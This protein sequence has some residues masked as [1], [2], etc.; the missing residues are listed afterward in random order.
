MPPAIARWHAFVAEPSAQ[1]LR[2]MLAPDAVFRSPVVHTPQVGGE[3]AFAYLRAAAHVLGPT[4]RYG[5]QWY[6]DDD[7]VLRFAAEVDG[8]AVD[9]IDMITWNDDGLITDFTVMVRPLKG[10]QALMSAMAQQLQQQ[11]H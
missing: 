5:R 8:F 10:L 11:Q 6:G 4:L 1:A 7:A 3:A 9:G 2:D